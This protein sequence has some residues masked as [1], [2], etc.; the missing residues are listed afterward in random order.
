M[1]WGKGARREKQKAPLLCNNKKQL[2][3][4]SDFRET[5]SVR[6]RQILTVEPSRD[7]AAARVGEC[8]F[9]MTGLTVPPS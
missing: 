9:T 8:L 6:S 3:I 5:D 7:C 2:F 1:G 4:E